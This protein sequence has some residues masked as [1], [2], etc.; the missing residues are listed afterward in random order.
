MF[1]KEQQFWT[2]LMHLFIVLGI[3]EAWFF[4]PFIVSNM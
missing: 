2:G 1:W 3:T 4:K